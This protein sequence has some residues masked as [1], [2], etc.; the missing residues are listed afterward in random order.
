MDH[1]SFFGN[2]FDN[3]TNSNRAPL[4]IVLEA[5]VRRY[6]FAVVSSKVRV[7]VG[8]ALTQFFYR[9]DKPLGKDVKSENAKQVYYVI[10]QSSLEEVKRINREMGIR[11]M[12]RVGGSFY[13]RIRP[14][15]VAPLPGGLPS[16]MIF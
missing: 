4:E 16:T 11:F 10:A 15:M 2:D 3:V 14:K 7:N 12:E 5:E 1:V 13:Y 9:G 8:T 6:G